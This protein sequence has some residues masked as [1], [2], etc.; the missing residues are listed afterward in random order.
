MGKIY[1]VIVDDDATDRY[2]A[3]RILSRDERFHDVQEFDTGDTFLESFE[4]GINAQ[5]IADQT[6]LILMDIN[7]PG[8][9]GF[10]TVEELQKR[11]P[12]HLASQS[13]VVMM[14]TS[15]N[16]PDDRARAE[17]LAAVKGY[18]LKPL[19]KDSATNLYRICDDFVNAA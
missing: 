1:V 4:D 13:M 18:I 16:N 19:D 6:F 15:S 9:N 11:M 17:A 5:S 10:E 14:F 8:R 12:G 3:R 7:M 2:I